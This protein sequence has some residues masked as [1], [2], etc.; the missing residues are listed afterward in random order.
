M[1][2][3]TYAC[4]CVSGGRH[5]HEV[6]TATARSRGVHY[7]FLGGSG[8]SAAAPPALPHAADVADAVRGALWGLFIGDALAAPLHWYY[9][10][11]AA[12]EAKRTL[13]GCVQRDGCWEM[14]RVASAGDVRTP[15]LG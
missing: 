10:W 5:A 8:G 15:W 11:P 4:D 9:T 1:A 7:D 13:Y 2:T 3:L 14:V 6:D 12:Q